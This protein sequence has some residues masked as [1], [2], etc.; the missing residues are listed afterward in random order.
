M[1][2]AVA[3]CTGHGVAG[4]FMSILGVTYIN[5]ILR[6]NN[7][8]ETNE[9]LERLRTEVKEIFRSLGND[10][11][12]GMDMAFCAIDTDT[13]ILE[14]S[15]AYNPA[16]IVRDKKMIILK[17]I[18]NPI[19]SHPVEKKFEKQQFQ[20]LDNDC[21]YLFSDGYYDQFGGKSGERKFMIKRFKNLLLEISTDPMEDQKEMLEEIFENWRGE[22]SQI[23]DVT[24]FGIRWKY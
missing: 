15:G 24:V 12:N 5:Q 4:A 3:D 1:F 17:P 13:N 8:Y 21:I 20:L 11:K 22:Q 14:F 9:I 23:D 2:F 7:I 10:S 18:K 6:R 19:G 16:F